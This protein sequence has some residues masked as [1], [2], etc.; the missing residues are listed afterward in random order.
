MIVALKEACAYCDRAYAAMTDRSAT[1][2]V[3]LMGQDMPKLGGLTVNNIHTIEHY[4]NLVTYLRMK[5]IVPPTS[6]REFMQQ[7]MK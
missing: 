2:T 5:N 7:M 1:E 4:G 6:D 3:K